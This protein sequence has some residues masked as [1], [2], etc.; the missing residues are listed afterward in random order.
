MF[1]RT[2]TYVRRAIKSK[3]GADG[4]LYYH[5]WGTG[6]QELVFASHE[7]AEQWA[8]HESAACRPTSVDRPNCV[9]RNMTV[10]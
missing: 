9:R 7:A 1:A 2:L 4:V 8:A 3:D 6:N 10:A 5:A